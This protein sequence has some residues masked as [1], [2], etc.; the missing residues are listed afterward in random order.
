MITVVIGV[1][2]LAIGGAALLVGLRDAA[3]DPLKGS[4]IAYMAA[5]FILLACGMIAFHPS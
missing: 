3:I 2:L 5:G 1:P 4:T